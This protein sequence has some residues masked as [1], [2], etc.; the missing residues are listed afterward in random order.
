MLLGETNVHENIRELL[1]DWRGVYRKSI[2]IALAVRSFVILSVFLAV[3]RLN[4][5]TQ[6]LVLALIL[7][8]AYTLTESLVLTSQLRL[9]NRFSRHR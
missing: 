7:M 9:L 4:S 6:V 1:E 8:I 3:F 5:S 2:Y